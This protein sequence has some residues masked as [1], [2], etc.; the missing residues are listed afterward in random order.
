VATRLES[1]LASSVV[2]LERIESALR[3]V[4]LRTREH[5]GTRARAGT[6]DPVDAVALELELRDEAIGE[7]ERVVGG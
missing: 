6:G 7:A 1:D 2:G 4:T 5:R 3:V